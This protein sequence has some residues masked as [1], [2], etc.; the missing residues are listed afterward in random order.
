MRVAVAAGMM[1]ISLA[2]LLVCCVCYSSGVFVVFDV[3]YLEM[4]LRRL[5]ADGEEDDRRPTPA[6][7]IVFGV[8]FSVESC[9]M[10]QRWE[11][12]SVLLRQGHHRHVGDD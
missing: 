2:V 6:E 12:E 3:A 8:S 5:T 10:L 7:A 4:A 9:G 1:V 11:L